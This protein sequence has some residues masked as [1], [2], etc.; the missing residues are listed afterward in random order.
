MLGKKLNVNAVSWEERDKEIAT[1]TIMPTP[2][3]APPAVKQKISTLKLN[4]MAK[5]FDESF[6]SKSIESSSVF[7]TSNSSISYAAVPK[8][9]ALEISV[10][11]Q[12]Q[13]A[14]IPAPS[15]TNG[16]NHTPVRTPSV[17]LKIEPPKP[18]E[19][20]EP[21]DS[22][23]RAVKKEDIPTLSSEPIGGNTS[24]LSSTS[25]NLAINA[26]D[27]I[28]I[29][30]RDFLL[31]FRHLPECG[32]IPENF[33]DEALLIVHSSSASEYDK[34]K[35]PKNQQ[36]GDQWRT[37]RVQQAN[38]PKN[39]ERALRGGRGGAQGRSGRLG[40][41]SPM[42]IGDAGPLHIAE[43]AYKKVDREGD[44][45]VM[46]QLNGILNKLTP[47]RL[48][49]LVSQ[50]LDLGFS[51]FH[52][53]TQAVN[54]IF[55]KAQMEP[56]FSP[57]YAEFC[58]KLSVK[59]PTVK[60]DEG[61]EYKFKSLL[62]N[63]CQKEFESH[64]PDEAEKA[65][66]Q[67]YIKKQMK[68]K[69]L[70]TIRFIGELFVRGMLKH[71]TV[72]HCLQILCKDP[73]EENIEALCKL[74]RTVGKSL[75]K[76]TVISSEVRDLYKLL[77]EM[78]KN[79]SFGFRY[80][81]MLQDVLDLRKDDWV[82][83]LEIL[84]AKKL[85]DVHKE[86]TD[87]KKRKAR[88][89]RSAD[90]RRED[91]LRAAPPSTPTKSKTDKLNKSGLMGPPAPKGQ[92]DDAFETVQSKK[93]KRL[94]KSS[95]VRQKESPRSTPASKESK[96]SAQKGSK[97]KLAGEGDEKK[98]YFTTLEDSDEGGENGDVEENDAT[99][100]AR[101]Q[102]EDKNEE[103]EIDLATALDG[104]KRLL[105]DYLRSGDLLVAK[106]SV[107]EL[108]TKK[109]HSVLVEKGFTMMF[110]LKQDGRALLV[111]LFR[112]LS[113]DQV[114]TGAHYITGLSP[115]IEVMDDTII[116]TPLALNHLAELLSPLMVDG[117]V[118][119]AILSCTEAS[120][121]KVSGSLAKWIDATVKNITALAGVERLRDLVKESEIKFSD[122]FKDEISLTTFLA[123][124]EDLK[125]FA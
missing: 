4:P 120:G 24:A 29:Y 114:L 80:R 121:L 105:T 83:R 64:K 84:Q 14:N 123:N 65:E 67:E 87:E 49:T 45:K 26:S 16:A 66:N 38:K 100:D 21:L 117:V 58:E 35:T 17:D 22:E 12:V 72:I 73:T 61:R 118:P 40:R 57:V 85:S 101:V 32:K 3:P 78:A 111:K 55:I 71:Q 54:A 93:G 33:P 74:L 20:F 97:K 18:I 125:S 124:N 82:D 36:G 112:E 60:N 47:E 63:Q 28:K 122:L 96:T 99:V 86:D 92:E 77:L 89:E 119:M 109:Y 10:H 42:D 70:G 102:P 34:S 56:N 88:E 41:D 23:T 2:L 1:P 90:K 31:S 115:S 106:Q 76:K 6:S 39:P 13:F 95:D 53:M 104:I 46:G 7:S 9:A 52:L 94:A 68:Q 48:D 59:F 51:S 79:D 107:A 11:A 81:C 19:P 37:T 69:Q 15:H 110:D 98:S 113:L 116:D 62:L 30:S 50:V 8:M 43:N 44:E 27:G 75:E 103:R 108:E 5:P 91:N 25:N